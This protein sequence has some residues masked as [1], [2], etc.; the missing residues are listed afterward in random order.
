MSKKKRIKELEEEIR[1]IRL[2]EQIREWLLETNFE[3]GLKDKNLI[4]ILKSMD[5]ISF[6]ER[7]FDDP[8][9]V[10]EESNAKIKE[11]LRAVVKDANS[12]PKTDFFNHMCKTIKAHDTTYTFDL[13]ERILQLRRLEKILDFYRPVKAKGVK[14]ENE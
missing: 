11:E 1:E 3:G 4:K 2:G 12:R 8:A 5:D 10:I 13:Y 7:D 9:F 6:F 14:G